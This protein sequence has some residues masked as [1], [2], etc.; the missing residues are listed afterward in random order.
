MSYNILQMF[1][2][3]VLSFQ[4]IMLRIFLQMG[5][6]DL[7]TTGILGWISLCCGDG[8]GHC[9]MLGGIPGLAPLDANH[10]LLPP[11]PL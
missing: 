11:T 5:F 3:A 2:K 7:G 6:L 1:I 8:P 4:F 9:G 10:S